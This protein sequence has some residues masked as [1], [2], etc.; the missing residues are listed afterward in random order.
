MPAV[1]V[2]ATVL[3]EAENIVRL[4]ESLTA[5]VP[6]AAEIVIV[7]GGSIDGTWEWL[8]EAANRH[9][10]LRPIRDQSCNLKFTPGPISK[11]RNVAI[12][13][14]ASELIA[15]ADAG[16]TYAPNWLAQLTAPLLSGDAEYALGGACLDLS[17]ATAWDLASAPFFGVKMEANAPTKSCTARSMAFTKS[18]WRRLGEFPET[19]FFGEDT[20]FDLEARRLTTPAFPRHAKALYRPRNS[21]VS[22]CRQM[23]RY[24]VSDGILGV[25]RTRLARNAARCVAEVAAVAV[26]HWTWI[27]LAV[28][29]VLALHF[30]F[31]QDWRFIRIQRPHVL[32]G[33]L[34]FSLA[35]PWLI[36]INQ[37]RGALTKQSL[38]N[39]QNAGA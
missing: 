27:P 31:T 21:F 18:L 13:A 17:D 37:I 20:L 30:A 12:A 33:R 10:S 34:V 16:C 28:V 38:V 35:V 32:A 19:V 23:A 8:R 15:C 5:Q 7:D 22:A 39:P 26:L 2:I 1:S 6:A 24:A 11:G 3:N 4:V 14:A 36:A 9:T 29:A 25:R